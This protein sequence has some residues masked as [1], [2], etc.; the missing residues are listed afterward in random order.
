[1]DSASG[2]TAN[3]KVGTKKVGRLSISHTIDDV[4]FKLDPSPNA[5]KVYGFK[6]QNIIVIFHPTFFL[7]VVFF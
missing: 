7:S 6:T 3:F 2:G 5:D 1:M 4:S